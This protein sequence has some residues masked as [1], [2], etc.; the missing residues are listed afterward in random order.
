MTALAA[1]EQR[2]CRSSTNESNTE[3]SR[4]PKRAE[5]RSEQST[6]AIQRAGEP[7]IV[8][9]FP[10]EQPSTE[11][12]STEQPTGG[13][14]AMA[15]FAADGRVLWSN[16]TFVQQFE[17]PAEQ[18][19][20]QQISLEDLRDLDRRRM[21]AL[22]ANIGDTMTLVDAE[23][24]ILYTTGFHADVL[25]YNRNEWSARSILELAHPDDLDQILR[26]RQQVLAAPGE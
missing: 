10:T 15:A 4:T 8:S 19:R 3:A 20:H 14:V 11:Q 16:S 1:T 18:R 13:D 22:L 6:G 17:S 21:Q 24:T 2:T 23:G 7:A 12:P 26:S 5:H 9:D 25:G